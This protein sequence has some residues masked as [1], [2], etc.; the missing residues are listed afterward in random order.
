MDMVVAGK[1]GGGG[2]QVKATETNMNA[3]RLDAIH[4]KL[5]LN[6]Q[7]YPRLSSTFAFL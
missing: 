3:L 4:H 7:P 5:S 2:W 1:E 6:K